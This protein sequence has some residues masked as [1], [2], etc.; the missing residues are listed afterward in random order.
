MYTI[1]TTDAGIKITAINQDAAQKISDELNLGKIISQ[2]PRIP[3]KTTIRQ[4]TFCLIDSLAQCIL[5]RGTYSKTLEQAEKAIKKGHIPVMR[6]QDDDKLRALN[7]VEAR[8]FNRLF[9]NVEV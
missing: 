7:P 5:F 6:Y 2:A 3:K 4:G 8:S 9:D 1:Y